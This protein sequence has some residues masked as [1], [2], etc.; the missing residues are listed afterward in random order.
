MGKTNE[1]DIEEDEALAEKVRKYPCLYDKSDKGYKER[2][3]KV[4]AWRAVDDALGYEEGKK[5][6]CF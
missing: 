1:C 3:R 4:N 2:D 6:S 5:E